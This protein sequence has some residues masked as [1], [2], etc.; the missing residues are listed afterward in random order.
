MRKYIY[1]AT[2]CIA[3]FAIALM[4]DGGIFR[5]HVIA[6]SDSPE[7]QAAKLAV[8]DAIL[9]YEQDMGDV[10]CAGQVKRRL[11]EDGAGLCAAID[12]VLQEYGMDY[13]AEL[14]IG[15]YDFPEREYAGKVYP[16]G[17]YEALRVVLGEGAG[18]NWWCVMFPPLCILE[19]TDGEIED[20]V[21]FQSLILKLIREAKNEDSNNK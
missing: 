20:E 2:M 15:E 3:A 16:E 6:N 14:H 8:R 18:K 1:T 21:K 5:L 9:R 17:R 10:V 7:D 12:G 13:G 4:F 19:A 11:M